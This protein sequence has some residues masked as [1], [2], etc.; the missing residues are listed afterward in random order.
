[1]GKGESL[2]DMIEDDLS[3]FLPVL[4][5]KTIS[6]DNKLQEEVRRK[7]RH[8]CQGEIGKKPEVTVIVS[9]LMA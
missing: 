9:R 5:P 3:E 2:A 6:D 8:L 7:V 4:K 1:M